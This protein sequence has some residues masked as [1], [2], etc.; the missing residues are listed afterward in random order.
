MRHLRAFICI[1][2]LLSAIV[3]SADLRW[4]ERNKVDFRRGPYNFD[5]WS[6]HN[7]PY[8]FSSAIHFAHAKQHDV[9]ELTPL[10][11]ATYFDAQ[12][13]AECVHWVYD[14]PRL[15]PHMMYWGPYTGRAAWHLYRAI[16]WTHMHHEQTYDVLA[17]PD[18]SWQEKKEYTDKTV[19]YYL[20]HDRLARS[21]APLDVTMRRANT[22]MKPYFTFFRNK[23]PQSNNFFYVAHWWHPVI[24][25]AMMIAGNDAEQEQAV[26][27]TH[28]L[29]YTQV[30]ED[31]PLRMLLSR[32]IMP[33]YSM[34]SPESAN[35]FDNLHMLHGIAYDIL[36]YEGW[37][38]E[39]KRLELYRVIEAMSYQPGDEQYVRKFELPYPDMDPR[40]Y[41][42]WMK[43]AEGSMN[44]IM[45]EMMDEMWPQMSP[46]GAS[47]M[48]DNL[49][50]QLTLKLTPGMQD[51]E[52]EG[53]WMDAL[54]QL[55]PN[56]KMDM[57]G[58]KPGNASQKMVD[59]MLQG[60]QQK[61]GNMP[62]VPMIDMST[63]PQLGPAGQP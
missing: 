57:E 32:E 8:R 26:R 21:C 35:I 5:F 55:E 15:E 12:F 25:E 31:R 44:K 20:T 61:Y 3:Q 14:L 19:D 39:Q 30:L 59:M 34:M 24:Y 9:L 38:I 54:K 49:R 45:F 6:R 18:I 11:R 43:P 62:D 56:V 29:L 40:V 58:S 60:W 50:Q 37:N 52:V 42:D 36:A 27:D 33:R 23:Y 47:R 7:E 1:T 16:D 28:E 17:S 4:E 53:A 46:D 51:G 22:M 13:N 48:P 41:A 63:D 2:L 10:Q